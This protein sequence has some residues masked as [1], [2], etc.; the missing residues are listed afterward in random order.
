MP[1]SIFSTPQWRCAVCCDTV[2]SKLTCCGVQFLYHRLC[3]VRIVDGCI[4][5]HVLRIVAVSTHREVQWHSLHD[6]CASFVCSVESA[7]LQ[8]P[9][10]MNILFYS[11]F[12]AYPNTVDF[13]WRCGDVVCVDS[14]AVA[15]DVFMRSLVSRR[16]CDELWKL[17]YH[18]SFYRRYSSGWC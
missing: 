10:G 11:P 16:S 3:M 7:A 14:S 8:Y 17:F 18:L 15:G 4:L 2:I 12:A 5:K 6:C 9:D 1:H 13:L